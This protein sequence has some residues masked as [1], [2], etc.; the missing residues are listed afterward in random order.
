MLVKF[1]RN[2]MVLTTRN[3]S[4]FFDKKRVSMNHFGQSVGAILEDVSVADTV[5]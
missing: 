5:V 3:C 1:E 4:G 2:R